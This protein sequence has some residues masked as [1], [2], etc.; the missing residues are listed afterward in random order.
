[1]G[2][3]ARARARV[4]V[5]LLVQSVVNKLVKLAV[6]S[7]LGQIDSSVRGPARGLVCS[8]P[9]AA[10]GR[11][12]A[13]ELRSEVKILTR[14]DAPPLVKSPRMVNPRYG[15]RAEAELKIEIVD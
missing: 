6:E 4:A 2:H 10:E 5:N 15:H 3:V 7:V 14:V 9:R 12:R 11:V 13:R 8:G 1:M